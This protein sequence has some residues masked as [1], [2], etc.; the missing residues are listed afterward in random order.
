MQK[1]HTF[2]HITSLRGAAHDRGSR[3]PLYQVAASAQVDKDFIPQISLVVTKVSSRLIQTQAF[4][5]H[6]AIVST[7]LPAK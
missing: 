4:Q 2:V 3:S 7:K 1:C 6:F 5:E